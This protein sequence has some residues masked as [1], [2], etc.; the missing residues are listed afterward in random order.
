[1]T[2]IAVAAYPVERMQGLDVLE[3]KLDAWLKEAVAGGASVAVFPEY[4]GM[5]AACATASED[6][7]PTGRARIAAEIARSADLAGQYRGMVD[8]LAR[9]HRLYVV[10]G[11]LPVREGAGILNRAFVAG[12]GGVL[13]WQDKCILTP[14]ER[15]HT[16]LRAGTTLHRFTTE[17]G[18]LG[19]LICYDCEFPL[20]AR[21]LDADV[22]AVPACTDTPA[23]QHRVQLAARARALESQCFVAHAP[24]LGGIASSPLVDV[25]TGTAGVFAPPDRGFPEDGVLAKGGPD[26]A[27]WLF[28]DLDMGA[29]ERCRTLGDVTPRRDWSQSEACCPADAVTGEGPYAPLK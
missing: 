14:W 13:G 3:A 23:G 15:A 12:P 11:S 9:R 28:A 22:L 2:R 21:R 26:R 27:G 10:A 1:M 20:L 24:L 16:S 6:P 8:A 4:A 19:V 25:N 5:E 29:L 17:F 18:Q 7:G